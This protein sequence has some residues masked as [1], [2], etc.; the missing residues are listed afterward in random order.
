MV[1]AYRLKIQE[2]A[3]GDLEG[4]GGDQQ[5]H[6]LNTAS[7]RTWAAPKSSSRVAAAV[8]N[9]SAVLPRIAAKEY[10][11]LARCLIYQ[12]ALCGTVHAGWLLRGAAGASLGV[13]LFLSKVEN[14]VVPANAIS[15][16]KACPVAS[17]TFHLVQ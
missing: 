2:R 17:K 1:F 9:S 13:V 11:V 16:S 3:A 15:S 10:L 6:S 4:R 8:R 12:P 5:G 7:R 14:A